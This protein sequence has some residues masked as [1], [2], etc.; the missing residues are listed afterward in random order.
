MRRVVSTAVVDGGRSR[1]MCLC[2]LFADK[3]EI[4][5]IVYTK[6]LRCVCIES[7]YIRRKYWIRENFRLPVF[8]GFTCFEMS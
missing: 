6:A 1:S 5:N 7:I 3:D 2:E 8:H 4:G